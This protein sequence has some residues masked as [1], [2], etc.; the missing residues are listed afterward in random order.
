MILHAARCDTPD[1]LEGPDSCNYLTW[2]R[3]VL[4]AAG[5]DEQRGAGTERP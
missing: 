1:A 2:R 3:T 4:A 5:E